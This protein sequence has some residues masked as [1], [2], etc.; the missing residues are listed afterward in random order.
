MEVG[1]PIWVAFKLKDN[2]TGAPHIHQLFA[3]AQDAYDVI[4]TVMT[5]TAE[6][7]DWEPYSTSPSDCPECLPYII[8]YTT[9]FMKAWAAERKV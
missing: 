8:K 6:F 1:D 2:V 7:V 3:T 5:S 4:N 9:K